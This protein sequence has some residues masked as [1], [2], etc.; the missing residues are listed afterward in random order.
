LIGSRALDFGLQLDSTT[1]PLRGWTPRGLQLV[2]RFLESGKR[3]NRTC[4]REVAAIAFFKF[5][6]VFLDEET[7]LYR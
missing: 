2:W 6:F 3:W 1:Q 4:L 5:F 7:G